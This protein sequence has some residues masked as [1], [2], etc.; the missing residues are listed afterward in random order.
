MLRSELRE[1]IAT[2]QPKLEEKLNSWMFLY[3]VLYVY[4]LS[5]PFTNYI[6]LFTPEVFYVRQVQY[7]SLLFERSQRQSLKAP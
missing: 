2:A 5:F 1:L 4:Q 6:N 7:H 3:N